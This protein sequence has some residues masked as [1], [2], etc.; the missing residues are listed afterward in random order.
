MLCAM[1]RVARLWIILDLSTMAL[2]PAACGTATGPRLG[3]AVGGTLDASVTTLADA[4]AS[5]APALDAGRSGLGGP[6]GVAA[7]DSSASAGIDVADST[8][9]GALDCGGSSSDWPMF[10]N[11]ICNTASQTSGG[12]ITPDSAAKLATKWVFDAAGEVS[13]TPSVVGGSVYFPDWGGMI[14]RVDAATGKAVWSASVGD[15]VAQSAALTG[16]VSRTTPLVTPDAVLF[17]TMR[18]VPDIVSTPG[19][20][21]FL[22]AIDRDTAA[23]K[24]RT[25]LHEGHPAAIVTSSP[26]LD[27][28][29]VY[30]GISSSEEYFPGLNALYTC[31]TFRGSVVAIDVQTGAV[32]W[33][34]HTIRDD[35]YFGDAGAPSGYSGAAVW[36]S[37]PVVD[38]KRRQLYV[39]TGNNYSAPSGAT[40]VVDGNAIDAVLALDLDTGAIK[41]AR[42]LTEGLDTWTPVDPSGPDADFGCGANLFTATVGGAP[43]DLVGAG[44]K[45]GVYWALDPDDGNVVW[46]TR[47]GPGGHFGGIHWGTAT[48]GVRIY[49]GVNNTDG[50][51][52]TLGGSGAHAGESVQTGAWS[53]LDPSTGELLWQVPDPALAQP[54]NRATVN[55]PV[56]VVDGVVFGGSMDASGTMFALDAATGVVL[57]SFKSGGTVYGGPAVAGGVVYWG[58]GYV[59]VR[60]GYGSSSKKL[61][62][63]W[64][65]P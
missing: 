34:T 44:Q 39:T 1:V 4:T 2:A 3:G 10:G 33:R 55:G 19:P 27:G 23:L 35:V 7:L 52:F 12:V 21:A 24:W 51:S 45:S 31:C 42:T 25:P 58:S 64:V 47:V 65:P 38:R 6:D 26:V 32:V 40:A 57:W 61:Y 14:Y 16:F 50:A 22:V 41:W 63:F 29:R 30:L 36:G 5:G 53:A 13:A 28:D 8:G 60:L 15:L 18:Q 17:G 56:A 46:K 54:L 62:A 20:S 37:T 48:D 9:Q 49:A 43:K 11:N 59:S